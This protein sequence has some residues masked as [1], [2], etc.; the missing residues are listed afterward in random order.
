[1]TKYTLTFTSTLNIDKQFV[2][3]VIDTA[4]YGINYWADAA[5]LNEDNETYKVFESDPNGPNADGI[6]PL[7]FAD[8]AKAMQELAPDWDPIRRAIVEEDAGEIDSMMADLII[9]HACF[10]EIIYG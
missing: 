8:I 4:G 2:L 1:M 3:D 5:Q 10:G 6:Y 9:Q 7:T